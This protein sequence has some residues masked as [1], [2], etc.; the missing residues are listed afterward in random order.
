MNTHSLLLALACFTLIGCGGTDM[1]SLVERLDRAEARATRAEAHA[2]A[3]NTRADDMRDAALAGGAP[4]TSGGETGAVARAPVAPIIG[5]GGGPLMSA[6]PIGATT[7][8][9]GVLQSCDGVDG[10]GML[11]SGM[12][13]STM[14]FS[15]GSEPWPAYAMDGM[16]YLIQNGS[17]FDVAVA[18]DGRVVHTFSGGTPLMISDT[19]GMCA[20]PAIPRRS[21][22]GQFTR[23][24]IPLVDGTDR[25]SH[26]ITFFCYRT[27][28]GRIATAPAH[29]GSFT[30]SMAG[31]RHWMISNDTCGQA[32]TP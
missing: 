12:L 29:R 14:A 22:P 15:P 26:E 1:R 27:A 31:G 19:S 5:G 6:M 24:S 17:I 7:G 10:A 21:A 8:M 11:T 28:G 18:I 30:F 25:P 16:D 3:A 32:G 2:E 23:M 9:P 20:M 4:D 13:T